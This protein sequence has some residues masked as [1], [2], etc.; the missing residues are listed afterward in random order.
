MNQEELLGF[1]L[2]DSGNSQK[3]CVADEQVYSNWLKN[4]SDDH[5]ASR[6]R[7]QAA[8]A[9]A[10]AFAPAQKVPMDATQEDVDELLNGLEGIIGSADALSSKTK[11]KG[12]TKKVR[13]KPKKENVQVDKQAILPEVEDAG[14]ESTQDFNEAPVSSDLERSKKKEKRKKNAKEPSY[15]ELKDKLEIT[16]RKSRLE[17]KDLKKKMNKLEKR[18]VEL[19]Q[20]LEELEIEN[21]TLIQINK[22]LSKDADHDEE[23][24]KDQ[25]SKEKDRKRREKRTSR[26]KEERKRE[27]NIIPEAIP[28]STN[29]DGQPIEF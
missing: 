19:E 7:S 5:N 24:S 12:K 22:R 28:S 6:E 3:K 16:T 20:R 18:N 14:E 8:A 2:N 1:L 23:A 13:S 26:R 21:Q 29:M 17:C 11:S 25:K 10:A 9:A 27:K 15:D 4:G